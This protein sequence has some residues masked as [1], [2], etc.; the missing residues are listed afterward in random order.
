M[1]P[2]L[3]SRCHKNVA[4]I[5]LTRIE[6]GETKN[7]GLCLKCAKELGIKPV[8]DMMQK[9]GISDEDLDGLTNE[10]MSAFGGAEGM[11]GLVPQ[12]DGES[13]EDDEGRT[14]TFPFLN[15]LF[16]GGAQNDGG[17]PGGDPSRQQREEKTP[18]K[19]RAP[20][21]KFLENYC[22]SLTG[23]AREGKLDRIVGRDSELER[24]VQILNRRQKNNPCLIG[25]P[26]VGKTAIAE[27][28]ALRIAEG[29]VPYKLLDKEVY[30][31]DLTS[32]VAG[33][34]FR[35]Q[36][37]SRMKGL[38]EEIKK[39]GNII[40]VID[41][42]HN[43]VGAGDAEGSMSAAN[44][45]KPALSRGEI[46]VIGATTLTEYRKYIEKDSALER[47]FQPVMVEEPSIKDSIQILK[48][49]APYYEQYHHVKIS[50]EMCRLAVT[51]SERYITD[52]FLPDKAIDLID[53]ASSDVNLHNKALTRTMQIDKELADIAKE[54]EVMLAAANDKSGEPFEKLRRKEHAL[55][56]QKEKLEAT[57]VAEGEDPA[58]RQARLS[59]LQQ[60]LSQVAQE[61]ENLERASSERAYQRLAV[62]KSQELQL[63]GEK[64]ALAGEL[65]PPLTVEHLA[66]VI[67]LWTKIPAS[68]IQEQEYERLAHLEERLKAHIIGQ[69]EAVHAVANAIRRGRVGIASKR[70]PVSFIFV[71]S[72][73]VGK[74]EL[75]KQLAQDMFNSP[76][77]LIRLDMSEFMEKFAVSRI[78]GSPPG[79]V[80]YDEAGQL[81]E[82]VRR[83][84]YCVILFDEIEKAHPDVLNIMLQILDDGHITDA[85]GRV[86]NFENTVIVMTSNAGSDKGMGSVGFG[87]TANEQGKDKALKALGQFLRP[88]FINRVDEVVY[89]NRLTEENFKEIA[90]LMLGEL[91]DNLREKGIT[92]TW[93]ESVLDHLVRTSYSVTYGARNLRR[94]VQ[95]DLEDPIA[96]KI[97]ESYQ[98]PITQLKAL[99]QDGK[100]ELLAL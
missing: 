77:S 59:E 23:Q 14:A 46:Q 49:I 25:E 82:K 8:E 62:L 13:D 80:G 65:N 45:L 31:L 4:V 95:K 96:T 32:L 81:T 44:I 17:A 87:R 24:V 41:E 20:K 12:G 90:K 97:I 57:P 84:P 74:T 6:G 75:V 47:R 86:V 56:Q 85:Q 92:F 91:T 73:G 58:P 52:R 69:D 28:L 11:E 72:T 60:Q 27:G 2:T 29:D 63:T 79:Y 89:F 67:E 93:D 34:Q 48:G 50:P 18:G 68:Q 55:L 19:E 54:R 100:L 3:C 71:G 98:H 16:G 64:D 51:M 9:M 88:E 1:Q 37:E 40:L 66:R 36:F 15:K 7:E 26:G 83:K 5:F 76:E 10:M 53:E 42:V 61:R 21:R 33:T 30:L 22:I 39:L 43:L 38:I 70:K 94:Q 78:I 99:E 35:G